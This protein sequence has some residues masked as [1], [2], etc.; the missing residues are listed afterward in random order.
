MLGKGLGSDQTKRC[1]TL[2]AEKGAKTI[3]RVYAQDMLGTMKSG[4][5]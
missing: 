4:Q 5:N 1:L 2:A 3:W